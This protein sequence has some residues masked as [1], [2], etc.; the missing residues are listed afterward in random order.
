MKLMSN[1]INRYQNNEIDAK[2]N[3]FKMIYKN[4]IKL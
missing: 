4:H 2:L 3:G 1:E